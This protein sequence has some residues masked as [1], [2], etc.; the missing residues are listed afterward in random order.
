MKKTLVIFLSLLFATTVFAQGG[1][2]VQSVPNT[3][4][5][6]NSIHVS[7]PDGYLSDSVESVI[8]ASLHAIRDKADIFLVT[9]YSI[10]DS[11]PKNF[12]TTLFNTWGIGDAET[13]NGVLL[14]FVEDQHALEFETGYGAEAVLTDAQCANIFRHTIVPYFKDGDYEGGLCAGIADIV[15]VYGG[16]VPVGLMDTLA[17]RHQEEEPEEDSLSG[18]GACFLLFFL[19]PVAI[20]SFLRWPIGYVN[21]KYKKD[22]SAEELEIIEKEGVKLFE[23][24]SEKGTMSVWRKRGFLRFLLYGALL[25]A[26][27]ILAKGYMPN[28]LPDADLVTQDGWATGITLFAYLSLTC[29]VQ[30]LLE[31]KKADTMAKNSPAPKAV[32]TRAKNDAHSMMM[33]IVAPWLGVFFGMAFRKRIKNSSFR[34]P[35]CGE[36]MEADEGDFVRMPSSMV[37]EQNLGA[38]KFTNYRCPSGHQFMEREHGGYYHN[39]NF[40]QYCGTRAAMQASEKTVRSAT[41]TSEG[42]KEVTYTCKYCQKTF[43]KNKSIPK[44]VRSS[45]SSS[46][47]SRYHGSRSHSSGGS[48]GGGHS[49]GG[50]YSGRW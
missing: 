31:L 21:N 9:L 39:Y 24:T 26:I 29:I 3:R 17:S 12:A 37:M 45:S 33:R 30:N 23:V 35:T 38:Y 36:V 47:S 16:E 40:C 11:D 43:T 15:E 13:D 2:T 42:L 10:G 25:V 5:E 18:L 6:S 48:F 49:G 4:L 41:Y 32:Y 20:I 7:D 34:C 50:G 27:Y 44:L 19:F 14:L 28:F 22:P 8:N 1:W 46:S